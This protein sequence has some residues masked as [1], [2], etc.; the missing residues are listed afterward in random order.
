ME[1]K[2]RMQPTQPV[3]VEWSNGDISLLYVPFPNSINNSKEAARFLEEQYFEYPCKVRYSGK[4][5]E[6]NKE[7]DSFFIEVDK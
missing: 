5:R 4:I 6:G 1:V 2:N 7:L 3:W